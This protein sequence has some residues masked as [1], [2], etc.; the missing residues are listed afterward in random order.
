M[1]KW[2]YENKEINSIE[3]MP[4]GVIGFVYLVTVKGEYLKYIGKKSL[5]SNRTL[6]PLKG[7]KRK[8]KVQKESDWKKYCGSNDKI[9]E[10]LKDGAE[11][12]REILE[13]A[14]TKY[15]LSYLEN[16]HLYT[17]RVIEDKEYLNSNISGKFYARAGIVERCLYSECF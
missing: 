14:Y 17:N 5:Y 3:D 6:L 7:K 9:K 15:Q 10:L 12:E 13:F 4:E 2:K 8:R 11:F 16:V 1:K